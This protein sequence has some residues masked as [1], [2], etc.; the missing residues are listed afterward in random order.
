M[1]D[2]KSIFTRCTKNKRLKVSM[3]QQKRYSLVENTQ[4]FPRENIHW[5][6][7]TVYSKHWKVL[8]LFNY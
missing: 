4:M 1:I 6:G 2:L 5:N 3:N 8:N 7:N